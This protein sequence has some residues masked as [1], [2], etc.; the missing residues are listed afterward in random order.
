MF[1]DVPECCMFWAL[2]TAGTLWAVSWFGDYATEID[3]HEGLSPVGGSASTFWRYLQLN[4]QGFHAYSV[5]RLANLGSGIKDS[6]KW[7]AW[8]VWSVNTM[9]R[10]VIDRFDIGHQASDIG[11]RF[12]F[13]QWA[14]PAGFYLLLNCAAVYLCIF[15]ILRKA[16]FQTFEPS[17][18]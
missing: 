10:L 12:F 9:V 3:E 16:S 18:C 15:F 6:S 5:R 17:F 2:S 14:S 1:R 4:Q 13:C 11:L 8:F 7:S